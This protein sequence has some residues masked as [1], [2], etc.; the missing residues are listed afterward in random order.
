MFVGMIS[1]WNEIR[2]MEAELLV[3]G[4]ENIGPQRPELFRSIAD[5]LKMYGDLSKG[6][7]AFEAKEKQKKIKSEERVESTH[8]PAEN[9]L[10]DLKIVVGL[11]QRKL[12]EVSEKLGQLKKTE[13]KPVDVP[14]R[15]V[16]P[17]PTSTEELP[18]APLVVTAPQVPPV[19][20]G[21]PPT[22]PPPPPAKKE[23]VPKP[24]GD[25]AGDLLSLLAARRRSM[26][27]RGSD[28]SDDEEEEEEDVT[29][30]VA[31]TAPMPLPS[32]VAPPPP[33][34]PVKTKLNEL[35]VAVEQLQRQLHDVSG[36]LGKLKGIEIEE[37]VVIPAHVKTPPAPLSGKA[38]MGTVLSAFK[39]FTKKRQLYLEKEPDI[40]T[41]AIGMHRGRMVANGDLV[42]ENFPDSVILEKDKWEIVEKPA[43]ISEP[44]APE[45]KSELGDLK[46][47][48]EAGT[49]TQ[50][51]VKSLVV[52]LEKERDDIDDALEKKLKDSE[53][54]H[55]AA[56]KKEFEGNIEALKRVRKDRESALMAILK[57]EYKDNAEATK[58]ARVSIVRSLAK[59]GRERL[60]DTTLVGIER[61]RLSMWLIHATDTVDIKEIEKKIKQAVK[62]AVAE[63][64]GETYDEDPWDDDDD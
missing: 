6:S 11:L 30:R 12:H 49:A 28:E 13:T 20:E 2:G 10:N 21:L 33:P 43:R 44:A 45:K 26:M 37:P 42:N 9:K 58:E 18:S 39:G 47:R 46:A 62:K 60:K 15:A 25:F 64:I 51:D 32:D 27:G 17:L 23:V 5:R 53:E 19:A 14:V 63:V 4:I 48:L 56:L 59:A 29:P 8:P 1:G 7:A 22:P 50:E 61:M 52:A 40:Y 57:Q 34:P 16:L 36:R 31:P 35:K 55:I 54:A 3:P 38:D 24:S 41:D